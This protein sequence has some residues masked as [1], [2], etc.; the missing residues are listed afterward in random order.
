MLRHPKHEL[1]FGGD[2]CTLRTRTYLLH[3]NG[4]SAQRLDEFASLT[5]TEISASNDM[6]QN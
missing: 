5:L 3:A 2:F 6:N 1:Q 4:I